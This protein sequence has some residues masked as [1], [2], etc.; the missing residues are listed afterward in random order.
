MYHRLEVLIYED[1]ILSVFY[2][3][4]HLFDSLPTENSTL[5]PVKRI[6]SLRANRLDDLLLWRLEFPSPIHNSCVVHDPY[7]V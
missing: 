2:L 1:T 6:G 7:L 4:L 5:E 3:I